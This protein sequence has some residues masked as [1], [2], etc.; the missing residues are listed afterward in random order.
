MNSQASGKY[1]LLDQLADEF[2]ERFRRGERP[3]LKEYMDRY[4]ELAG[5]IGELLPALVEIAQADQ[6]RK[7]SAAFLR[8]TTAEQVGDYRLLR[9]IGRGG[10]GIVYEAEQISLG[11]RVALKILPQSFAKNDKA[12]ERFKRESRSA[13]QLHHTNIVPVFEVGQEG[14][15]CYYS[16]QFIQ[17]QGLDR[18]VAELRRLRERSA[19]SAPRPPV[20]PGPA[21]FATPTVAERLLSGQFEQP[22]LGK[23]KVEKDQIGS[24]AKSTTPTESIRSASSDLSGLTNLNYYRRIAGLGVQLADG[25]A[26]ANKQGILHRDIK[27][28]NLLLDT[29]GTLWITDFGL[30]RAEGSP[31]LTGTGEILGTFRYM[32]PERFEGRADVRSDI[33]SCGVTLYELLTFQPIFPDVLGANL[34]ARVTREEPARPRELD[35]HIPRDLETIVLKAM[36][37]EPLRRYTSADEFAGDLRRFLND[38]PIRARRTNLVERGTMWCRRNPSVATLVAVVFLWLS[39]LAV[40]STAWAIWSDLERKALEQSRKALEQSDRDG[41]EQLY[42]ALA[43]QANASHLNRQMGQRHD[44]LEAVR[45]A[46]KLVRERNM[47]A[48]RLDDLRNLAIAAMALPDFKVVRSW[49]GFPVGTHRWDI[50]DKGRLYARSTSDGFISLRLIEKDEEM[51]RLEGWTYDFL[52]RFSPGGR[53]L[54][55]WGRGHFRVWDV[56]VS[57]PRLLSEGEANDLEFHPDGQ[58]LLA[59]RTDNK[60]ND[61]SFWMYD[62]ATSQPPRLFLQVRNCVHDHFSFDTVGN[63]LAVVVRS[64][65]NGEWG[66]RIHIIDLKTRNTIA[67]IPVTQPIEYFAWHPSGNYLAVVTVFFQREIQVWEVNRVN[68]ISVLKGCRNG[69]VRVAFTPNGDRLLSEGWEGMLRL[70]DWQCGRE[71]LRHPAGSSLHFC[72]DGTL[73]F[74]AGNRLGFLE[75]NT[76]REHR[77]FAQ[78]SNNF[79]KP[80][81]YGNVRVHPEGRFCA[82][83][84]SD[85]TPLFDIESGDMLASLPECR[86][87]AWAG[88]DALITNVPRD[89]YRWPVRSEAANP[90]RLKIGPPERLHAGTNDGIGCDRDGDVI[91]QA[92]NGNGALLIRR[93]AE[94][95][96]LGP[97]PGAI[98]IAI[99]PNGH[100]AATGNLTGDAGLNVW[101]T[102]TG[103]LVI[104][105]PTGGWS[106]SCFSPDGQ[107]LA[108]RGAN[109]GRFVRVES[110]QEGPTIDWRGGATF[111]HDGSMFATGMDQAA[112]HLLNPTNGR[113]LARLEDPYQ[114]RPGHLAFT[115]DAARLINSSDDG[116]AIHVWDLRLI[117]A[118]LAEMGLDWDAPAVVEPSQNEST[119]VM[120]PI[121]IEVDKAVFQLYLSDEGRLEGA[122]RLRQAGEYRK[123]IDLLRDALKINP[124]HVGLRDE[125]AWLLLTAPAELRNPKE[126]LDLAQKT[127]AIAKEHINYHNTLGV[128]YYR[129]GKF[130]QAIK[131]L[132]ESLVNGKGA[133]DGYDLFFLAMCHHHLGHAME[134]RECQRKAIDWFQTNRS[135]LPAEWI[136]ELTAFQNEAEVELATP[137]QK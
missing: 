80:I 106:D 37:K 26:Y 47:P 23:E 130:T 114:D 97:H 123:A 46:T 89:L 44:S 17:G 10:M 18:V 64:S 14:D 112:I 109:G 93:G 78:Q 98:S 34:M 77:S 96:N 24:P 49:E 15:L 69:G 30:A 21:P 92:V 53:Y 39:C 137:V 104:H 1:E 2:A 3:T 22:A 7:E 62:L 94:V 90:N 82:V 108:V 115:P 85:H 81:E 124:L 74:V 101:N 86:D 51:A 35:P 111:S 107:W 38:E 105:F 8:T 116:K 102:E 75:I 28:S 25:L 63:R 135:R 41:A 36:S 59:Q 125:L 133:N 11:R 65:G 79:V 95:K 88:K 119:T 55:A 83:A 100:F 60:Y 117:R 33:Y 110:W 68:K 103:Q 73:P 42:Q 61:R 136:T 58:H 71:L 52:L 54:L 57:P 99:S 87:L 128:A 9:E 131:S 43:T 113:E 91:G 40:G 72:K 31:E 50:D 5:D 122:R 118:Q 45:K 29:R 134:A 84:L 121:K 132:E 6:G 13:A 66:N 27:P 48:E 16:M 4:P 129:N 19:Q 126:A 20:A 120:I 70:W 56:A 12:V 32:P 76:G 127:F 67:E